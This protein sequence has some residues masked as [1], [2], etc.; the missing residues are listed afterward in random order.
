[1]ISKRILLIIALVII[2]QITVA[3][4]SG[5]DNALAHLQQEFDAINVKREK[6]TDD[7]LAKDFEHLRLNAQEVSNGYPGRPEPLVWQ[8][9]ALSEYAMAIKSFSSMEAYREARNK[10][11]EALQIDSNVFNGKGWVTL[12]RLY[13]HLP[14][15]PISYGNKKKAEEYYR[16]GLSINPSDCEANY[17]SAELFY[18]NENYAEAQRHLEVAKKAQQQQSQ[19]L[20]YMKP[21]IDKLNT[22]LAT[23]TR[24]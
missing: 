5:F 11:E 7:Q 19:A 24:S 2:P 1:M 9:W 12:A 18:D 20:A 8:A 10:L 16:K 6:S 22:K 23:K 17:F 13:H 4:Q 3:E 14:R 15:W 21:L